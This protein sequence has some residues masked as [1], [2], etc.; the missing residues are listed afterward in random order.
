MRLKKFSRMRCVAR[1][2]EPGTAVSGKMVRH[3]DPQG[4]EGAYADFLPRR[5]DH[6][7]HPT[8][9]DTARAS[10]LAC[11]IVEPPRRAHRET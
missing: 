6:P 3:D 2:P 7:Y 9:L 10:S 11:V 8:S 1:P 5:G 4:E